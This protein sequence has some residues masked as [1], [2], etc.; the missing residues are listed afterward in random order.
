M[1]LSI[2]GNVPELVTAA[3]AFAGAIFAIVQWRGSNKLKRAEFLKEI[4][5]KLHSDEKT[6]EILYKIEYSE[7]WYD[8]NFHSSPFE[9]EIDS[10]VAFVNYICYLRN[11]KIIKKEEFRL[12]AY[13][14]KRI[15]VNFDMQSYLWNLYNF[16]KKNGKDC[17]FQEL[18]DYAKSENI[19]D[20]DSRE[21][22]NKF[23]KRLNF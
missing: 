22:E 4:T 20:V 17:S 18:I 21:N 1:D 10:F 12:L 6:A 19:F 11:C 9:K 8:A 15:C 7:P 5:E 16:S 14:V 2:F 23:E 3:V 13:E